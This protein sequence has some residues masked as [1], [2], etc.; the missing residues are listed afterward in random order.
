[1][2]ILRKSTRNCNSIY[3]H[4]NVNSILTATQAFLVICDFQQLWLYETRVIHRKIEAR[5]W[6]GADS[7]FLVVRKKRQPEIKL[8]DFLTIK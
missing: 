5:L 3:V 7:Q 2:E 8:G 1:M 4:R 6:E